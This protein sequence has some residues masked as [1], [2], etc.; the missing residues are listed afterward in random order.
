MNSQAYTVWCGRGRVGTYRTKERAE[1]MKQLIEEDPA[2][3]TRIQTWDP[4]AHY[5]HVTFHDAEDGFEE[6][7]EEA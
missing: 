6:P 4:G 1:E 2:A 3:F 5:P 7:Q